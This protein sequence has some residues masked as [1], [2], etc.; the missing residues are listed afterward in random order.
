MAAGLHLVVM[1]PGDT[2]D[3]EQADRAAAAGVLVQPLSWH[4]HRPGPPGLV[5]G[6][7]ALTPDRL[8]EAAAILGRTIPSRPA[9]A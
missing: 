2:P 7:A 8:Q 5:L 6:Y 9:G 4:R 1:L 3:T